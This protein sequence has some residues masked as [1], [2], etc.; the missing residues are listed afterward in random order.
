MTITEE[1]A[2]NAILESPAMPAIVDRIARL[3]A[4]EEQR[5]RKFYDEITPSMKAEFINGQVVMHS[6]ATMAHV[7]VSIRLTCLL[8]AFILARITN[9][10]N[11]RVQLNIQIKLCV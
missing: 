3:R 9:F 4:E 7:D 11:E 10:Q 2:I 6:P 1:D 8:K 5:R